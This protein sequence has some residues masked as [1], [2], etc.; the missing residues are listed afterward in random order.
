MLSKKQVLEEHDNL[1]SLF[2]GTLGI[3]YEAKI[4]YAVEKF[5]QSTNKKDG[6]VEFYYEIIIGHPFTDGNKRTATHFLEHLLELNNYKLITTDDELIEL[7]LT[8]TRKNEL[9][10]KTMGIPIS[11]EEV[12][13][14][15]SKFVK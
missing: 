10:E 12:K 8:I 13:S 9:S 6:S 7:A 2:G 11:F 1:V 4:D 14:I 3:N 5:N 15:I